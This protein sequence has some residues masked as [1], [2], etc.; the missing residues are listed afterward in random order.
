MGVGSL[1]TLARFS[2]AFLLLQGQAIG[3]TL[4]Y[5]PVILIVMNCAYT[6][7]AYPAGALSDRIDPKW[8][9]VVGFLFLAVADIMIGLTSGLLAL[10]FGV[11]F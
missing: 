4:A 10:M 3:L 6:L 5:A 1:L 11:V 7:T 9:L 8:L 2:E